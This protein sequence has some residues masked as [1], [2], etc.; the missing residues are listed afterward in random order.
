MPTALRIDPIRLRT[1]RLEKA[2]SQRA[3]ARAAGLRPATVSDVENGAQARIS[4]IKALAD[5]L[6][7]PPTAIASLDG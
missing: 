4:T 3:L 7:V 5:A 1:T 2:L 6:G